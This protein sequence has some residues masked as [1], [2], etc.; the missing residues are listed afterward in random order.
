MSEK[1][2]LSNG[3]GENKPDMDRLEVQMGYA[4]TSEVTCED[5]KEKVTLAC[6]VYRTPVSFQGRIKEPLLIREALS[7]LYDVVSSDARYIPK[8]RTAYM[9]YQRMRK[10]SASLNAWQA[11]QAYFEWLQRNDPLAFLILD[12]IITVHPDSIFFEV[13][14][15]DESTYARLSMDHSAFETEGEVKYGTTNIDYSKDFFAGV[16]KMRSYRE[17]WL[18]IES[19]QVQL[20]SEDAKPIMEKK[21]Q[22][23]LN[24]IRGFLQVQSAAT[25]P[26]SEITLNAIDIYNALRQLRL[27]AD[28]KKA[29]RAIRIELVP[30]ENPRLVLEPWETLLTTKAG[31][32]KGKTPRVVKIWGRR[33]LMLLRR[34]LPFS[35][36][37]DVHLLGSGLPSF[38]VLHAGPLT[39]TLGISGFTSNNWSQSASFDLLLPRQ[40][41][42][43]PELEKVLKHLSKKHSDTIEKIAK[44]TKMEK[45]EVIKTLQIGCQH[46]K[47]MYD[48]K[49]YRIRPLTNEPLDLSRLQYR[50]QRERIA[51]DLIAQNAVSIEIENQIYGTGLE[52]T[53]NVVIKAEKRDYR[54]VLLIGEDGRLKKAQCTC[55]FYRKHRLKEGPCSHLIA[56]RLFQAIEEEKR[57]QNREK[58]IV[59]TRTFLKR[60]DKKENIFQISLDR[61]KLKKRW[62]V[63]GLDLRLQNLVFNTVEDARRAYY[64]Q[65][66]LLEAKGFLDTTR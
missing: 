4:S 1:Q 29:G 50:N 13:F 58:I 8:D 41:E 16:Q 64:T 22:V 63:R 14:S 62:G 45:A 15:K 59:E 54:P 26:K 2:N 33:R 47:I 11:R 18:N 61:K 44:T 25:L 55:S 40:T 27:H 20:K 35:D 9:A 21:V 10:Q 37:V 34:I 51:Y 46:G 56:L 57:N 65:I 24:W 6:N 5:G 17:S 30:G 12:P 52:L 66:D 38:F 39:F 32:Y 31:V 19:E 36:K 42:I 28:K 49:E 53:G 3:D 23:P 7:A 48:L 60:A 43:T